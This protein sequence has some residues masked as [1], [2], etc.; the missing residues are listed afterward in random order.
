MPRGVYDHYKIRRRRRPR[1][2]EDGMRIPL[3]QGFYAEVDEE[4]F[5]WLNSFQW[6]AKASD[7][8][9]FAACC[10]NGVET[11]M[12]KL[13]L[14]IAHDEDLFGQHIDYN[15]LNN[16]RSNLRVATRQQMTWHRKPQRGAASR[17]KG[18]HRDIDRNWISQITC[19]GKIHKSRVF[20]N[21]IFAALDY[22]RKARW[23]FG[24]YGFQ[25]FN[26]DGSCNV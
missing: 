13:I 12:Q 2:P 5:N 26:S 9:V 23:Y 7:S 22:D 6:Y 18:V 21:E 19:D 16:Q 17:Y 25:N 20:V 8:E 3:T 15:R 1:S 4:D 24:I 10:I 11:A 14:G